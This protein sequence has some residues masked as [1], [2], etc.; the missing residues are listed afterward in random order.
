MCHLCV[1]IGNAIWQEGI[2]NFVFNLEIS[3]G[4][5]YFTLICTLLSVIDL[6]GKMV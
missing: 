6:D 4:C 3:C 5:T 1:K 2:S